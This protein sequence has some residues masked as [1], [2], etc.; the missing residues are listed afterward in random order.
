MELY[1][2]I[3][4]SWTDLNIWFLAANTVDSVHCY[5]GS[6]FNWEVLIGNS[7][8]SK[9]RYEIMPGFHNSCIYMIM[10]LH[11]RVIYVEAELVLNQYAS[12]HISHNL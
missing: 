7:K 11:I 1:H 9:D 8:F 10:Y 12:Y 3:I 4:K 2:D 5:S 6:F